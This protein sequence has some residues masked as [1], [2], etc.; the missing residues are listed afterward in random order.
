V[1]IEKDLT[2]LLKASVIS[3]ETEVAIRSY[4]ASKPK[5]TSGLIIILFAILGVS[6]IGTGINLIIASNWDSLPIALK[7]FIGFLPLVLAQGLSFYVLQKK[8]ELTSWREST[9][10]FQFLMVGLTISIISQIYNLS[11][12]LNSFL[13]V[14]SLLGLPLVYLLNSSMSSALYLFFIAWLSIITQFEKHS[15]L[16]AWYYWPLLLLIAPYYLNLIKKKASSLPTLF[17][18]WLISSSVFLGVI[19]LIAKQDDYLFLVLMPLFGLYYAIS[20][21]SFFKSNTSFLNPFKILGAFGVTVILPMASYEQFWD[22]FSMDYLVFE[23]N[24]PALW[25]VLGFTTGIIYL[26]Y[27]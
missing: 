21:A 6:F 27:K 24:N 23:A 15:A 4:Y 13:L 9:A 18:H 19:L 17:H 7:T 8:K 12:D 16:E 3:P 20:E 22:E 25:L 10:L 1:S 2:E 11:G 5:K 14:W 26:L